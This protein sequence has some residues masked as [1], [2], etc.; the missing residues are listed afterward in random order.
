MAEQLP[1][2][3]YR[4][5]AGDGQLL[6]I[7]AAE[8]EKLVWAWAHGASLPVHRL[9]PIDVYTN[10][11]GFCILAEA[12]RLDNDD[13]DRIKNRLSKLGAHLYAIIKWR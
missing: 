10:P 2:Y 11:S 3:L 8:D 1:R 9:E 6:G 4:V 5:L 12:Q 13:A 7:V